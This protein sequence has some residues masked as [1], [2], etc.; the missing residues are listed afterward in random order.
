MRTKLDESI[1][2]NIL[3][4]LARLKCANLEISLLSVDC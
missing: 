1:A 3:L 2:N 4:K